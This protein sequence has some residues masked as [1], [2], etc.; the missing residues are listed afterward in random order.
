MWG[1][2]NKSTLFIQQTDNTSM[3]QITYE[4]R[5]MCWHQSTSGF[6]DI[7]RYKG[8]GCTIHLWKYHIKC[9]EV[10]SY[11][12]SNVMYYMLNDIET[13]AQY[14]GSDLLYIIT[15]FFRTL[16][17]IECRFSYRS[18]SILFLGY[19]DVKERFSL[20]FF[21]NILISQN[22]KCNMNSNIWTFTKKEMIYL[23][24]TRTDCMYI[25]N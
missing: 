12:V 9:H 8:I 23:V 19:I 22:K 24:W 13:P 14:S 11:T 4:I 15:M 5:Y 18:G 2:R 17:Y 20:K 3:A 7:I 1:K 16:L 25:N 10:H 21:K 6:T